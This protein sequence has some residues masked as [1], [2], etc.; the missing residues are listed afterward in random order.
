MTATVTQLPPAWARVQ[1]LRICF[2]VPRS[3]S[4][5]TSQ[6]SRKQSW[7]TL[8]RSGWQ[9]ACV[10]RGFGKTPAVFPS[11]RLWSTLRKLKDLWL[12]Q[13]FHL[14]Q[15]RLLLFALCLKNMFSQSAL[16]CISKMK[17]WGSH[18][19]GKATSV[20]EADSQPESLPL[21]PLGS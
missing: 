10:S 16:L 6:Q 2:T 3:L 12:H 19:R 7:L 8:H 18:R 4:L 20:S 5:N 21:S 13:R 14:C 15:N 1:I 9:S 17:G 11:S